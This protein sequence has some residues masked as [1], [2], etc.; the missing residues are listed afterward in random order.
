V[1]VL[2]AQCRATH[3]STLFHL[4]RSNKKAL[5]TKYKNILM[6]PFAPFCQLM[7]AHTRAGAAALRMGQGRKYLFATFDIIFMPHT[8]YI[9]VAATHYNEFFLCRV[10]FRSTLQTR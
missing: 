7:P 5:Q 10:A 3:H 4:I 6:A 1:F 8:V 9:A 2:A